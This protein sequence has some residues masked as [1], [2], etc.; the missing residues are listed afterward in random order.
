MILS[1][2]ETG[3]ECH[4]IT[5]KILKNKVLICSVYLGEGHVIAESKLVTI[6][7]VMD[8]PANRSD[9]PPTV[10]EAVRRYYEFETDGIQCE[11]EWV[12]AVFDWTTAEKRIDHMFELPH[13]SDRPE[14][15]FANL[16]GSM[17]HELCYQLPESAPYAV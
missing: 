12:E 6:R 4:K 14:S 17:I 15:D 16:V 13:D 1:L 3:T 7:E 9:P 8:C 5:K 11:R 10:A 2:P